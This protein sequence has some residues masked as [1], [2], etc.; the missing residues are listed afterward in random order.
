MRKGF[1][2]SLFLLNSG[3]YMARRFATGIR[4]NRFA[5]KALS[6]Y[7][8]AIRSNRLKPPI[9]NFWPPEA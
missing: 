6:S 4:A 3:P 5:E 9:R 8:H 1:V 7:V 2:K